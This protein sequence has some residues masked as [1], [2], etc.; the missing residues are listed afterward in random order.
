MRPYVISVI[1]VS[2]FIGGFLFFKNDVSAFLGEARMAAVKIDEKTGV[3]HAAMNKAD[4]LK[5][6]FAVKPAPARI[7]LD[8]AGD[9]PIYGD[10]EG[11]KRV[12]RLE[13]QLHDMKV[14]ED[15]PRIF[16]NKENLPGIR[17]K[18]IPANSHWQAILG[19]AEKGNMINAAF[20]FAVLD[21]RDHRGAR[22]AL[23]IAKKWIFEMQP[24]ISKGWGAQKDVSLMALA[25]DWIY[26]GLSPKERQE[27]ASKIASLSGIREQAQNIK[28]GIKAIGETFHREE[29]ISNSWRA[30]P[31][32]ALAHHEPE[33]EAC[34]MARWNYDWYWGDAARMYAYAADGTPFEGYYYGADGLDW[35]VPLK[36]STGINV[37]DDPELGW[38]RNAAY[39]MLYRL[40]LGLGREIFHKGAAL[41][42]AGLLSYSK[43]Q[44][45][46]KFKEMMGRT[47]ALA[48]DDP[49]CRWVLNNITGISSWG[50]TTTGLAG[51][52]EFKDIAHLVYDSPF[53]VPLDPRAAGYEDLPYGRLFPGGREAYMRTSWRGES[54]CV[55]F[56][57]KPAYTMGSHSDFDVNTFMIYKMGNLA[58][59]SGVYDA[60]Q[61]QSSYI[62]YQK[63]TIAHNDILV[64]D[65]LRPDAPWK[66]AN[67]PDPGGTE[68]VSNRTFGAVTRFG[69]TDAFLHDHEADWTRII[70]FKSTP[71][72]DY[73][74]SDAARAYSSRLDEYI[75][76][77]VFI[78]K[79]DDAY[80]IVFDRVE[81]K[82][83]DFVKKWL[84]HLVGEPRITGGDLIVSNNIFNTAKLYL[85]PLFPTQKTISR[86]GGEGFE[87]YVE[88]SNPKNWGIN[89][90]TR[91]RV[92][93]NLGAPWQEVGTWRIEISPDK[94]QKRDYFV[95]VMYATD[96]NGNLDSADI[97]LSED[98]GYFTLYI[99]DDM[100]GRVE[101]KLVKSGDPAVYVRLPGTSS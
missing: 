64:I 53:V 17:S 75:R 56:T 12:A 71:G 95:N 77:L 26:N 92:E 20:V 11:L 66:L 88:G 10:P 40:D 62:H 29:W 49:Y 90:E 63:N 91:G 18:A 39:Y 32:I 37:V 78:R 15:H 76:T 35:F 101:I 54:A 14:R 36:T 80:I 16:I 23:E 61:G 99:N 51:L 81:A 86:I 42:N 82:K 84:L 94:K 47:M 55:G 89:N 30:W 43:G 33:A 5:T 9:G 73:I 34:Y 52:S 79:G 67:S 6:A 58:P 19:N 96:I 4:A 59:D 48:S 57:S 93:R 70:D 50:I 68:R 72:Y 2:I 98:G 31:E 87:F 24:D 25:F 7:V 97:T 8:A 28:K 74:I 100:L 21:G 83:D 85:K 45:S 3:I 46:W 65:P 44:S 41:G 1:I 22:L 38:C 69:L 60:Y 13:S 27:L